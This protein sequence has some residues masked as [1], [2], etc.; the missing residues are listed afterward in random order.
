MLYAFIEYMYTGDVTQLLVGWLGGCTDKDVDAMSEHD[1][2]A[3]LRFLHERSY[4]T[5]M[6]FMTK[7]CELGVKDMQLYCDLYGLAIDFSDAL[8]V[9]ALVVFLVECSINIYLLQQL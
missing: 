4:Y 3:L 2:T 6:V 9:C 5:T 7:A 8:M 1:K